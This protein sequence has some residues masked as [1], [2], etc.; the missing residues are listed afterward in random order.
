MF[1]F[2]REITEYKLNKWL[3]NKDLKRLILNRY[4][5]PGPLTLRCED[6]IDDCIKELDPEKSRQILRKLLGH[7]AGWVVQKAVAK[8]GVLDYNPATPIEKARFYAYSGRFEKC[9]ELGGIA[10]DPLA[11]KMDFDSGS[12]T[13]R[14]AAETIVQIS[15]ERALGLF[16]RILQ[17]RKK[18]VYLRQSAAFGLKFLQNKKAVKALIRGLDDPDISLS[19]VES[20]VEIGETA[21]P[22]VRKLLKNK[23]L[24]IVRYAIQILGESKNDEAIDDLL[25]L[26]SG[27]HQDIVSS[28]S[29]IGDRGDERLIAF[30]NKLCEDDELRPQA[31]KRLGRIGTDACVDKIIGYMTGQ[32]KLTKT[33]GGYWSNNKNKGIRACADALEELYCSGSLSQ[34]NMKKI[35][36]C[37]GILIQ[38][39]ESHDEHFWDTDDVITHETKEIR[40]RVDSTMP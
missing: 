27:Y 12:R 7:S 9:L 31:I 39:P 21:Y 11:K 32:Y 36:A 14:R 34:E 13:G 29:A 1:G 15:P 40:F 28:L 24:H 3:Q 4:K 18:A 20:L 35:F 38:A 2:K 22:N 30:L 8:L 37:N 17:D 19:C 5:V 23:N 26:P 10:F 25:G 33:A 16:I 6:C